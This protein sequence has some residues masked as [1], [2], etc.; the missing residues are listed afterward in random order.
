[1]SRAQDGRP[2]GPRRGRPLSD[3]VDPVR[4]REYAW[5]WPGSRTLTR[6]TAHDRD[7]IAELASPEDGSV[8]TLV[9]E[10]PEDRAQL[11]QTR[12]EAAEACQKLEVAIERTLAIEDPALQA[13]ST[14]HLTVQAADLG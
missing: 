7:E 11:E 6:D 3:A 2:P 12:R 8:L 13:R 9:A 5:R 1:M 10:L 4:A 14:A